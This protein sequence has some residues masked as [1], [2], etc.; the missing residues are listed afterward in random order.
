MNWQYYT[1]DKKKEPLK[2]HHY[3]I[4]DTILP[5]ENSHQD[6]FNVTMKSCMTS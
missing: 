5:Q 4:V 6:G 2:T 1:R 3:F